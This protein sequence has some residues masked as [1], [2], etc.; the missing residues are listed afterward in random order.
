MD[1]LSVLSHKHDVEQ[2]W[3][4]GAPSH[5]KDICDAEGH[6][7]KTTMNVA[8]RVQKL[9][10][11]AQEPVV[12]AAD[13]CTEYFANKPRKRKFMAITDVIDHPKSQQVFGS[14]RVL[15][16][17]YNFVI[18]HDFLCI[19]Q[20]IKE[21]LNGISKYYCFLF[22]KEPHVVWSRYRSC[23]CSYCVQGIWESCVN[24]ETVG[25]WYRHKLRLNIYH[26]PNK[27]QRCG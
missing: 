5:N 1:G 12:T 26:A 15:H 17:F 23:Y 18:I 16:I 10:Y 6:A 19:V 4:Y 27:R 9:V 3:D 22:S 7:F 24:K 21:R 14:L 2:T 20:V 13:F 25:R 11:C 8:V